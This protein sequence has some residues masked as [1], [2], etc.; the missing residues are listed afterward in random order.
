MKIEGRHTVCAYRP[1]SIHPLCLFLHQTSADHEALVSS[2]AHFSL[3]TCT[4]LGWHGPEDK[5][6]M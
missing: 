1:D 5:S 2:T 4:S 3:S 6:Y